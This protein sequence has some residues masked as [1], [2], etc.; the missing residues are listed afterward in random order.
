MKVLRTGVAPASSCGSEILRFSEA[1]LNTVRRTQA[2]RL[3]PSHGG[4]SAT[5]K[6]VLYGEWDARAA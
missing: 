3:P 4:T 6:L 5:A 2:R 1:E